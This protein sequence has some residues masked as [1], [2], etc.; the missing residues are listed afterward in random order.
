L[1]LQL[2][3]TAHRQAIHRFAERGT[4]IVQAASMSPP[5]HNLQVVW[6]ASSLPDMRRMDSAASE[7]FPADDLLYRRWLHGSAA[8][9]HRQLPRHR[10]VDM[11]PA[12]LQQMLAA[13]TA[14]HRSAPFT[15]PASICWQ[16]GDG[17]SEEISW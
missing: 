2:A 12:Q 5:A 15:S 9:F 7:I 10:I 1:G 4:V 6:T 8:A 13:L 14:L 3:L 17:P 11:Q 16:A